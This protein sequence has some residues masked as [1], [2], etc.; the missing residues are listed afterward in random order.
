MSAY[1]IVEFAVKDPDVY[2]EKYAD[3]AG[4]TAKEY[5]A[6]IL[7]NSNWEVLDGAPMLSSG[8]IVQFPDHET[9]LRWYNSPEYQQLIEVRG[10]AIDARFSLLDGLPRS[11]EG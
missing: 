8:V 7:A 10:I 3:N 4:Q 6:E 9:A 1:V 5:G 2:R 11:T